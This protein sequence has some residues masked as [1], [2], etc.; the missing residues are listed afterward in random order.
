VGGEGVIWEQVTR[1]LGKHVLINVK[2]EAGGYK[3]AGGIRKGPECVWGK[4][5]SSEEWGGIQT[6]WVIM[7]TG[8]FMLSK[9]EANGGL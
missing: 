9:L 4:V 3:C 7:R 1:V 6:V 5:K 8:T 2:P